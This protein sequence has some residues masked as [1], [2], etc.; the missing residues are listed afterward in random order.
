MRFNL[1]LF[2][3]A[4]AASVVKAADEAQATAEAQATG[5]AQATDAARRGCNADNCLRVIRG[6]NRGWPP[7][8]VCQSDCSSYLVTTVT[9][10]PPATTTITNTVTITSGPYAKRGRGR[11]PGCGCQTSQGPWLLYG[12]LRQRWLEISQRM[13]LYRCKWG[14]IC[15]KGQ[16]KDYGTCQGAQSCPGGG[17]P[18]QSCGGGPRSNCQW[19]ECR[20]CADGVGRCAPRSATPS[21]WQQ[22]QNR[23][24]CNQ[25]WDCPGGFCVKNCCG[26]FCYYPDKGD[27]CDLNSS[28]YKLFRK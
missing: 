17:K 8:D 7:L 10:T 13:L 25:N 5:D 26:N 4:I 2:L 21:C 15:N 27:I 9:P 14:E 22:Q 18:A 19:G 20:M 23:Q 3:V 12:C 28:P 1:P 11:R 6:T 24:K 16:C